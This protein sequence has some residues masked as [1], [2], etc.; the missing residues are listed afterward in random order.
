[1]PREICPLSHC[2]NIQS[3]RRR[4]GNSTKQLPRY[5]K[6]SLFV[7]AKQLYQL[8]AS[9]FGFGQH[10]MIC[11]P[12]TSNDIL[13]HLTLIVNCFRRNDTKNRSKSNTLFTSLICSSI[14]IYGSDSEGIMCFLLHDLAWLGDFFPGILLSVIIFGSIVWFFFSGEGKARHTL[15]IGT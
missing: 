5:R 13:L 9:A 6:T 8:V 10:E 11:L 14:S 15:G 1:M 3:F 7:S 2:G 12:L 4:I